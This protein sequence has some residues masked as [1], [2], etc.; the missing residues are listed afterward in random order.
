M[1]VKP[2]EHVS[3]CVLTAEF[4]KHNMSLSVIF[5]KWVLGIC[6]PVHICINGPIVIVEY[7]AGFTASGRS[8]DV[9]NLN[10]TPY[11]AFCPFVFRTVF[12]DGC[13]TSNTDSGIFANDLAIVE[14]SLN[15]LQDVFPSIQVPFLWW[16]FPEHHQRNALGL[17]L[18]GFHDVLPVF[19]VSTMSRFN[20]ESV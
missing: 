7:R 14:T 12:F 10:I 13:L 5:V 3:T 15:H 2:V 6:S 4:L 20:V 9:M 17:A 11:T 18:I 16:L 8:C 1:S 19:E